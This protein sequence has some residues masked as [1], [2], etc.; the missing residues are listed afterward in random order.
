MDISLFYNK[1]II[2]HDYERNFKIIQKTH[3]NYGREEM[4]ANSFDEL[5]LRLKKS[6][7]KFKKNKFK[8]NDQF[9]FYK[10]K[11]NYDLTKELISI[12]KNL[13]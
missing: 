11:I 13:N 6:L 3:I 8:K 7:N 4:F 10:N 1:D 12:E 2:V 5:N 9:Y